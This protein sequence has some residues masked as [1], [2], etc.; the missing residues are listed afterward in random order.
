MD[1]APNSI[2]M[3]YCPP[4]PN[5]WPKVPHKKRV[6]GTKLNLRQKCVNHGDW[7][8]PRQILQPDWPKNT[9]EHLVLVSLGRKNDFRKPVMLSPVELRLRRGWPCPRAPCLAAAFSSAFLPCLLKSASCTWKQR[10]FCFC[11]LHS[12]TK[13]QPGERT[14][15]NYWHQEVNSQV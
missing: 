13:Y 10:N 8:Q 3:F 15:S 9:W 1:V 4:S 11:L 7:E 2:K 14:A 5:Y 12:C 6:V